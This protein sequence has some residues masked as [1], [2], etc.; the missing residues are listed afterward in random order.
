MSIDLSEL[1]ERARQIPGAERTRPSRQQT[2]RPWVRSMICMMEEEQRSVLLVWDEGGRDWWEP[3]WGDHRE[4][5]P[6]EAK[7]CGE[8]SGFYSE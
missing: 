8:D 5:V 1:R 7:D 4:A 2:Q 6:A 3:G